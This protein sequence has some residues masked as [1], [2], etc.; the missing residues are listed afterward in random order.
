MGDRGVKLIGKMHRELPNIR[1]TEPVTLPCS[2][3]FS[4]QPFKKILV[5][6]IFFR[7][8][9][10]INRRLAVDGSRRESGCRDLDP[11]NFCA[12]GIVIWGV[13]VDPG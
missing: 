3:Y 7:F 9:R 8:D 10:P 5:E 4:D 2:V 12:S 11:G 6:T 13:P 1:L